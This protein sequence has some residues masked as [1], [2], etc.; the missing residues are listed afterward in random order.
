MLSKIFNALIVLPCSRLPL[1]FLYA[2]A[3]VFVF[4][5]YHIFGYRKSVV[6][7]NLQ[8]SFPKKS[9]QE[10]SAIADEFYDYFGRLMA[11][12]IKGM[13]I[14]ERELLARYKVVN[15]ELVNNF[16]D[17][18][19]SVILVSG[20]Y[21][22]W[23]FMVQSLNLQFKHQGVGVGKPITNKGFGGM[24]DN[25]RMRFGMEL[26]DHT[27]T[28]QNFKNAIEN[29]RLITCM[30]LA[31]QS[32]SNTKK[33]FWMKFLNQNTPT[34]FGPE[35]LAVKYNVP[36]VFY[37]VAKIKNGYFEIT[38][39]PV[40]LHPQKEEYGD[41][42]YRHN[43]MLEAVINRNPSEWLWSHKRWKHAKDAR[44]HTIRE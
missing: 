5:V 7:N 33:S 34:I 3:S 17:Q 26:W 23:E 2:V 9:M 15:P 21:N 36:V 20:H 41:I 22:N 42:T 11:E 40:S 25:A 16:Y 43:K 6:F 8:K 37:E 10:I 38:L 28:R 31:D 29:K 12:G 14:S 39:T 44:N 13:T 35:Y 19:K 1:S 24:M 4:V 27:N 30:L 32:P 18:G